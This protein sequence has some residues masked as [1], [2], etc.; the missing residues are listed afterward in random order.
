MHVDLA[1][2]G[3]KGLQGLWVFCGIERGICATKLG[4]REGVIG[5]I[6]RDNTRGASVAGGQ[7]AQ[8]PNWAAAGD[9]HRF[10]GQIPSLRHGV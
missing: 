2:V 1:L 6:G 3:L 7:N 9:Q 10:S 5:Q 8:R 4:H